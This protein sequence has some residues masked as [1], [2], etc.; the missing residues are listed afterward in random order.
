MSD[1]KNGG[2]DQYGAKPLAQQ[3]YGTAGVEG[4]KELRRYYLQANLT[5]LNWIRF[6]TRI[7]SCIV[8]PKTDTKKDTNTNMK[9]L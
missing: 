3:Q 2:L 9:Q 1:I 8:R 4:V 7:F 6:D 5:H